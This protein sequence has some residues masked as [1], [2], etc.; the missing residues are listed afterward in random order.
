MFV[1]EKQ[2]GKSRLAFIM[3]SLFLVVVI[4]SGCGATGANNKEKNTSSTVTEQKPTETASV[5]ETE[6]QFKTIKTVKGDIKVPVN[7]K[8]IVAEEYLGS[9]IALDVIPIGAPALTLENYYFKEALTGVA[10]TGVYGKPSIEN[11][12]G[13]S[14]DLIITGNGDSYEQLSKIAPTLFIPYGDLKNAHEELTYFGALFNKEA[15]AKAWLEKF[16]QRITEAKA[17]VDAAIPKDAT[18]TIF[19]DAGKQTWAYGDNFGRGGQPIYQALDRKP[20][21][22]IAA[23][24]MEKQW[25]E[26]ST[27][28]LQKYAGDYIVVTSN[29]RKV[30]DFQADPIWGSLPAVKNGQIYVWPE[31]RSW[32]YDPLAVLAQ[33]EELTEWLVSKKK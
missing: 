2:Q 9:L 27:E 19:E 30:E 18:F 29:T 17:K 15:E 5:T 13:L 10:D 16:D 33:T 3:F 23:E 6:E 25:A 1:R 32:Y 4:L 11:I 8:R 26:I 28:M 12:V 14:P 24:I 21:T 31:E 22:E 20:P 7:P